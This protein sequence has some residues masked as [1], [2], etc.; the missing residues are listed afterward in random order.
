VE[1]SY[2]Q[3]SSAGSVLLRLA[4]FGWHKGNRIRT[5]IK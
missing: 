1:R 5:N 3:E 4:T 2:S